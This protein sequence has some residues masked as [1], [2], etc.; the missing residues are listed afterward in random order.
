MRL[1]LPDACMVLQPRRAMTVKWQSHLL[2]IPPCHKELFCLCFLLYNCG[3][4]LL[5]DI[6]VLC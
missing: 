2:L 4:A 6:R 5:N 3:L 1:L